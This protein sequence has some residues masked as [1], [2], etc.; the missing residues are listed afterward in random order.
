MIRDAEQE[1]AAL[2]TRLD[3]PIRADWPELLTRFAFGLRNY[4]EYQ[5]SLQDA[6]LA[7]VTLARAPAFLDIIEEYLLESGVEAT[8]VDIF[9]SMRRYAGQAT[10][11][12]KIGL[13]D[14]RE[15]QV[16]VKRPLPVAEVLFWLGQ[17]GAI[18]AE[19]AETVRAVAQVLDKNHTHFVGADITPGQPPRYQIYFTQYLERI[20]P[21]ALRVRQ[22]M[23]LI[24]LPDEVS[25]DFLRYHPLLA[26]PDKTLWLSVTLDEGRLLPTVKLD[27]SA[28]RLGTVG[29]LLESVGAGQKAHDTLQALGEGLVI[30]TADYLGVRYRPGQPPGLSLYLTRYSAAWSSYQ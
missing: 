11:G 14:S 15:V 16:Y 9:R 24:G 19:A 25:Q 20:D 4:R 3:L 8:T 27:Y 1:L 23:A 7:L 29:L 5:L 10:W 6:D 26:R 13:G 21:V 17:R 30:D 2:A 18:E 22:V 12:L 28:V